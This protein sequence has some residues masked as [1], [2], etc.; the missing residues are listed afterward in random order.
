[1]KRQIRLLIE[2]LFDDLYDIEQE[3][4]VTIDIADKM[5]QYK[6]GDIYYE[7]KKPYAICCGDG[8]DFKDNKPRFMYLEIYKGGY[9]KW[10]KLTNTITELK[11]YDNDFENFKLFDKSSIKHID[12]DG[13]EN[14]QII[15]NNYNIN[16]FPA[17]RYCC[18][19]GDNFYLP[20]IDELQILFL[21]SFEYNQQIPRKYDYW[22]SSQLMKQY[23]FFIENLPSRKSNFTFTTYVSAYKKNSV[24]PGIIPFIKIV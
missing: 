1:M 2:N 18:D 10:S 5:Y 21:N 12:E 8:E 6:S 16:D 4:N 9:L 7:N 23:C 24:D 14:T 3:N 13:Y 22:S 17:F 19:L 11:I 20:A 15:K